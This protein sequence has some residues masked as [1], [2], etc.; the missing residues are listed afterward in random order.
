ME[1]VKKRK[2]WS[3]DDG[4]M[5][6]DE[7]EVEVALGERMKDVCVLLERLT[8]LREGRMFVCCGKDWR[9]CVRSWAS[10]SFQPQLPL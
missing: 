5:H 3:I 8:E 7:G 1:L 4:V 2:V 10:K 9:S 6:G